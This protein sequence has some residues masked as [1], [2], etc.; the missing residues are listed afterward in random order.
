MFCDSIYHMKI[1]NNAVTEI[2]TADILPDGALHIPD[3]VTQINKSTGC[4]MEKLHHLVL[5][6]S[7]HCIESG[8]FIGCT[9]LRSIYFG[10]GIVSISADAFLNCPN[11]ETLRIPENWTRIGQEYGFVTKSLRTI[12]RGMQTYDICNCGN[13]NYFIGKTRR[14]CGITLTQLSPLIFDAP[15]YTWGIKYPGFNTVVC[16]DFAA[17]VNT[18]RKNIMRDQWRHA[19]WQ[20]SI[21][22]DNLSGTAYDILTE[23]AN[24]TIN[25]PR[26][27]TP[28]MRRDI[29]QYKNK[30][31]KYAA[32][33]DQYIQKYSNAHSLNELMEIPLDIL[34]Q[35]ILP[36]QKRPVRTCTRRLKRAP[37]SAT[38]LRT[39]T[40]TGAD[41]AGAF[42]YE[43]TSAYP[44]D[45]RGQV[46]RKIHN[47]LRDAATE[48]YCPMYN[49]RRMKQFDD[50]LQDMARS[51]GKITKMPFEIKYLAAGHFSKAFYISTPAGKYIWKIYHSCVPYK[52]ACR[53]GHDS[54]IQNAF[55]TSNKTYC[56][57][58]RF[59]PILAAG[60]SM[61]RGQRYGLYPYCDGAPEKIPTPVYRLLKRYY[62]YDDNSDKNRH[63]RYITDGGAIEIV[64]QYYRMPHIGPIVRTILYRGWDDLTHILHKYS[65][66]QIN[67]ALTFIDYG[68]RDYMPRVRTIRAKMTLLRNKIR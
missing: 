24:E 13:K 58:V 7:L 45:M 8:A 52:A 46:T 34:A 51:L 50:Q 60:I 68:L 67:D 15:K 17:T 25:T 36:G 44:R 1:E 33:I 2:T 38:E 4:G 65:P 39:I 61:Q 56:G 32:A 22:N 18:V 47:I 53:W 11:I 14:I 63:G 21:E 16:P 41:M 40:D 29:N 64:D 30:I 12:I 43:W 10:N 49:G 27:I 9:E 20:Y 54:E 28:Q 66:A 35:I 6:D 42:P 37:A 5:P 26:R 55:L 48:L 23:S 57:P 59:R 19:M 62:I 3:G 31:G